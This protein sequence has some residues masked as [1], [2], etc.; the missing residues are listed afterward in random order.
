MSRL[1]EK[2]I[3][4]SKALAYRQ[5]R[6]PFSY[7]LCSNHSLLSC[8]GLEFVDFF[9]DFQYTVYCFLF[10]ESQEKDSIS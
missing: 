5:R 6:I 2:K 8:D 9:G 3:D 4:E 7:P 1:L 10:Q